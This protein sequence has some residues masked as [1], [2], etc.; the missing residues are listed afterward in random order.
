MESVEIQKMSKLL[1]NSDNILLVEIIK[2]SGF[3]D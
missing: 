2:A 3:K 1:Q